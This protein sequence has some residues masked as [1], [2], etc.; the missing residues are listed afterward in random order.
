MKKY[1]KLILIIGFVMVLLGISLFFC[2]DLMLTTLHLPPTV[3]GLSLD[4][5][6][7]QA[8]CE[9]KGEGTWLEGKYVFANVDRD[10]CL[11]LIYWNGKILSLIY[12]CCNV[13]WEMHEI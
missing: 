11:V 8:F 10:G 13:Y 9:T 12:R 7:P 6:S 2:C 5:V 1:Y 3:C 4:G